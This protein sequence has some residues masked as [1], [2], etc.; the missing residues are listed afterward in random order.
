MRMKKLFKKM[1]LAIGIMFCSMNVLCE[2]ES[3]DTN[4]IFCDETTII[5][6]ALFNDLDSASFT[7]IDAEIINNCLNIE[8]EASGCDAN[9]WVFQ[10]VDSGAIAESLPEQRFLKCQLINEEACL[11]SFQRITSF[12]LTPIQIEGSHELVLNIEGLESSLTYKY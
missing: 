12:D 6:E 11:A 1:S 10:L 9:T 4:D 8:I 3:D 2:K 7:F 5:S